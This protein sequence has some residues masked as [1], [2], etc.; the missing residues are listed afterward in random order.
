MWTFAD[1]ED[2]VLRIAGG[3]AAAG[4]VPGERILM[5]LD[6][7]ST[8][9]LLFFGAIAGGFVPMPTSPQLTEP[10]V[11]FLLEDSGAAALATDRTLATSSS[12]PT[13]CACS[14]H[15]TSPT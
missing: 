11:R 8:Y 3:L 13:A 7:T 15:T 6:N 1:L 4:M 10:E 12:L 14:A 9:A 5:Q 2:A